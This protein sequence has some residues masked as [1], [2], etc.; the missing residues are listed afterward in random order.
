MQDPSSEAS[1]AGEEHGRHKNVIAWQ[2]HTRLKT[3]QATLVSVKRMHYV[4][5]KNFTSGEG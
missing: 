2:F 4:N 3:A 5:E 1:Q